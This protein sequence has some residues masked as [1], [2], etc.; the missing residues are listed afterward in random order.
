MSR[1]SNE[2]TWDTAVE[3]AAHAFGVPAN[4]VRAVIAT[5]TQF[6]PNAVRQEA[7]DKSLGLMQ[8]LVG[9]ARGEGFFGSEQELLDPVTNIHYGTS[10]L[11]NMYD[12]AGTLEGA[13]SAYNGGWR[14]DIGFGARATRALTICLQRDTAG[15][16]VKS[17][18]VKIGEFGNQPYVDAVMANYQ[19][20]QGVYG[21]SGGTAPSLP[22]LPI[23]LPELSPKVIGILVGLLIG[24][25]G[26]QRRGGRGY[27][28]S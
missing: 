15:K 22:Q 14:P 26:L 24:L 13:A 27:A 3:D 5:E 11:A 12:T 20:F 10:Y 21:D 23:T 7:T 2:R 6:T 28:R 4:L 8:I 25:L 9:T 17:R 16:C 18:A 19:Y 1:W